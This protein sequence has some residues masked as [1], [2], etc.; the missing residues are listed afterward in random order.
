MLNLSADHLDR[1]G[2]MRG[3]AHAKREIF[4]RQTADDT[5]VV[6]IDDVDSR[7]M[8]DWL[9]TQPARMVTVS[10]D[11]PAD[12]WCD[13]DQLRDSAGVILSMR[14]APS[15][16]GSH[17]GQNA[18]AAAALAQAFN[19][20]RTAIAAG[21]ASFSGLPHRQER[22]A[23]VNGVLFVNDSKATNADAAARA[24]GCYDRLVWIAGGMAKAGGI[25]PL[26]PFLPRIA[27]AVLIGRDAAAL[28]STLT[29]HGVPHEVAGT[30]ESAVPAAFAAALQT[31]AEVVLLSPA[32]ASFD[33][34]TGFDARGD[35]FRQLVLA[36]PHADGK[37]A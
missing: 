21:I 2:S 12:I 24:L 28:A 23:R 25:E 7:A 19:V 6:G 22:I 37:A 11:Q 30:L 17:N 1:H 35:R 13:G 20:D 4:A 16:P 32:C 29:Q 31:G 18:A 33:Q 8:A 26:A 5:A 15:L 10:G 3:Y 27:H 9:R 14:N 34:F 36:L